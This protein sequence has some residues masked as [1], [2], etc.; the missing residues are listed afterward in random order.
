V[1]SWGAVKGKLGFNGVR[2]A[3]GIAKPSLHRYLTGERRISDDVVRRAPQHLT[4][5]EFES[6]VTDWD[7]LKA[8]GVVRE[9]GVADYA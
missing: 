9:D 1:V 4:R 2:G 6:I 7:R 3:L 8:L 5:S